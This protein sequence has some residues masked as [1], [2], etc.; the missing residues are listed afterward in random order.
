MGNIIIWYVWWENI[1]RKKGKKDIVINTRQT[2]E[3]KSSKTMTNFEEEK[4]S[5]GYETGH[6]YWLNIP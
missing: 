2:K 1:V 6:G 4:I 3:F 5:E